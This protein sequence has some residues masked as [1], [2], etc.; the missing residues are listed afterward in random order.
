MKRWSYEEIIITATLYR[1][2]AN[3]GGIV[4]TQ[5]LHALIPHRSEAACRDELARMKMWGKGVCYAGDCITNNGTVSVPW[6]RMVLRRNAL[7]AVGLVIAPA[8]PDTVEIV[9]G[10]AKGPGGH[11]KLGVI[12]TVLMW[13]TTQ[14][15]D[16]QIKD[17]IPIVAVP[18]SFKM[19]LIDYM[20]YL[21]HHRLVM[22]PLDTIKRYYNGLFTVT[23]GCENSTHKTFITWVFN[24]TFGR[25]PHIN[26]SNK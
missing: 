7:E 16:F 26:Q 5:Q 4:T 10:K 20:A 18:L 23:T 1:K 3:D 12:D 15:S 24:Y 21:R 14:I 2:H 22:S 9:H 19:L 8:S 17:G 13:D 11:G 25:G 6:N